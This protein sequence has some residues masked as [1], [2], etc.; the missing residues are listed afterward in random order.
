VTDSTRR[1]ED[2]TRLADILAAID[3]IDRY[4]RST[5]HTD[6]SH[7]ELLRD[8]TLYNLMVEPRRRAPHR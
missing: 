6:E 5:D 8:A 1:R 7:G 2:A 3:R 4:R